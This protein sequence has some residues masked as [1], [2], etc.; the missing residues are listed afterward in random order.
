MTIRFGGGVLVGLGPR[1]W[2]VRTCSEWAARHASQA[3]SPATRCLEYP[4]FVPVAIFPACG[5]VAMGVAQM[6]GTPVPP[7]DEPPFTAGL[8]LC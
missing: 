3:S 5:P 2:W 4:A 1:F 6:S 8:E 7:G